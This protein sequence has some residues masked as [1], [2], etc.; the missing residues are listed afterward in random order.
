MREVADRARINAFLAALGREA[1]TDVQ[2]FLVGGTSAVLVG[3]RDATV[4]VD[5]V[6]CPES[7]ALL[8]AIPALKERLN[9]NVELA[10]PDHF[11][12]V[13]PGWEDRSP[14]IGSIGR[15]TIR[16][17]DF[18]A[19]ALSKIERGHARDL[20][21]VRAMIERG[22]IT[23]SQVRDQFARIEP[24]LYRYPAVDPASFRNAVDA[25]FPPPP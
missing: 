7:D 15:M 10:A 23:A 22:L 25:L 4:D 1:T 5:L 12:P 19:Q 2:V 24:D 9:I 21:D 14:L 17:Y 8:R 13:S 20:D 11:I 3:W 6:M 16:H 18:V